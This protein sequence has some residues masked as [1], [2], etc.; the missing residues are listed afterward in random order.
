MSW[1]SDSLMIMSLLSSFVSPLRSKL[2]TPDYQKV[3][4]SLLYPEAPLHILQIFPFERKLVLV[5]VH[6]P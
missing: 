6:L 3:I 1:F 5:F 2:R 4:N